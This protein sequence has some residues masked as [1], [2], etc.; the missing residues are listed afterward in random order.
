MTDKCLKCPYCGERALH[1]VRSKW[2]AC[3]WIYYR[4]R[5]C[6][7]CNKWIAT[8]EEMRQHSNGKQERAMVNLYRRLTKKKRAI[9]W[10][11]VRLLAD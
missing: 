11:M 7:N 3:G 8:S 5:E 4:Y 6:S 9:L 2:S 1:T 10:G